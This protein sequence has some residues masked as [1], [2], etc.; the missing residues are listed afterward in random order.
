[1]V[2][3]SSSSA[4][5]PPHRLGRFRASQGKIDE[6]LGVLDAVADVIP[7]GL[8]GE[9]VH[10]LALRQEIHGVGELDL[11]PHSLAGFVDAREDLGREDVAAGDGQ[12]A[13]R[14][15]HGRLLDQLTQA[16]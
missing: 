4:E 7:P 1:V 10:G 9:G 16:D 5:V 15:V 8:P 2:Y 12:V 6:A 3:V 11:A 14:L 13:R